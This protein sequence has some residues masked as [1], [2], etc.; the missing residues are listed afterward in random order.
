MGATPYKAVTW[1][2]EPIYKDKLNQM[3]NNEQW[4]FENAPVVNYNTYGIKRNAGLKIMAGIAV[5]PAAKAASASATVNFGTFFSSGCKP[6]ITVGTQP[7]G[8]QGR[9][10]VSIKGIDGY[11]PDHRGAVFIAAPDSTNT[12]LNVM[13]A[14]V[15]VH[16]IAIGW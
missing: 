9:F 2:D 6:V 3:T 11:Y 12:K 5:V 7:T 1:G 4:L 10:H 14:R 13:S 16:F 15:Y 8:A